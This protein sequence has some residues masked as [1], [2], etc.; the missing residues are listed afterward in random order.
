MNLVVGGMVQWSGY[1]Q[2]E[3]DSKRFK[4]VI[5]EIKKLCKMSLRELHVWYH[6]PIKPILEY[7]F[8]TYGPEDMRN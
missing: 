6:G 2:E 8:R 7:N 1:D 3:D 5:T 4:M